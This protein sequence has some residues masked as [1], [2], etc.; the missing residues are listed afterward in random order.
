MI[1]TRKK[2]IQ[3]PQ[4]FQSTSLGRGRRL[5]RHTAIERFWISI[6]VPRV[7]DDVTAIDCQLKTSRFQSTSPGWRTTTHLVC[8]LGS[9]CYFNPRPPCG[10][11]LKD[12]IRVQRGVIFQSTSPVWRTT[13]VISSGDSLHLKFQSTSPVWRTTILSAPV[14]VDVRI[15]IHVP[16]VEDDRKPAGGMLPC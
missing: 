14:F 13:Y 8:D 15:S 16:R 5:I 6:H 10:G 11:R 1:H 3:S 12:N 7:E 9:P 4:I 2:Y